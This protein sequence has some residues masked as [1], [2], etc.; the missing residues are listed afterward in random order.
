M[1]ALEN[2]KHERFCQLLLVDPEARAGRVYEQVGYKAR[3]DVAEAAAS[4]LLRNVKVAARLAQLRRERSERTGITADRVLEEL[5]VVAFSDVT[6]YCVD[7]EGRVVLDTRADA[8]ATRALSS[9][10]RKTKQYMQKDELVTE[11][12]VEVK[13][14][15]KINALEQL[16]R[17]LGL[18]DEPPPAA[19]N[20]QVNV[21]IAKHLGSG[22]LPEF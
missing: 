10:K 22:E 14:W 3:G 6:H 15:N 16:A 8:S 12:D 19:H 1:P 5:A 18:F 21:F 4:R 11:H 13:L 2:E 17:H 20:T 7:E 9:V